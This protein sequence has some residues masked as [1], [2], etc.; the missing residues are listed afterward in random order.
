MVY[1]GIDIG[2][3]TT[4]AVAVDE[5]RKIKGFSWTK[6]SFNRI[7]GANHV[8]DN[9]LLKSGNKAENII[10][11][12]TTGYGRRML[13]KYD[14]AYPE[15]V[16]HGMG[17]YFLYPKTRTIIDI[18]GQDSKVIELMEDGRIS[19]F[20]MNDKCAA[21]T[22]RFF[23]VLTRTLLDIDL[24]ELGELSLKA[25]KPSVIS[26]MCTVFAESEIVSLMSQGESRENIIAGMNTAIA[27]RVYAMGKSAMIAY[28]NDVIFTGGVAKNKGV[29]KIFEELIGSKIVTMEEPQIT[30]ALGAALMVMKKK[31]S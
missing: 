22:G 12:G 6:T 8:L 30:G 16:C 7:D 10:A 26:S 2:S 14:G 31:D 18:G 4:K 21:G 20:Q 1:I 13:Q 11:I 27:K 9:V 28:N 25:N 24:N 29:V 19:K 17:T 23:E 5:K 15:I 3:T